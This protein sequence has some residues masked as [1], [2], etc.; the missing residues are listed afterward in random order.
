MGLAVGQDRMTDQVAKVIQDTKVDSPPA[1]TI[2]KEEVSFCTIILRYARTFKNT[3]TKLKFTSLVT[4]FDND[5]WS[6]YD[7]WGGGSSRSMNPPPL[8][9]GLK[10]GGRGDDGNT[11]H[12]VLMRGLPYR[13]DETDIRRVRSYN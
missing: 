4:G 2:S 11:R 9:P 5:S 1:D 8:L 13:A 3:C 7:S 6:S 10:R 12:C